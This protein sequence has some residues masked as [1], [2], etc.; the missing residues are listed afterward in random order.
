M[1]KNSITLNLTFTTILCF[2]AYKKKLCS[3]QAKPTKVNKV[4]AEFHS[5]ACV[6]FS[7]RPIARKNTCCVFPL[8]E[9]R[10]GMFAF[11]LSAFS[12][13]AGLDY[14]QTFLETT[15]G[16]RLYLIS[17]H[18]HQKNLIHSDICGFVRLSTVDTI[19]IFSKLS[20]LAHLVNL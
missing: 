19:K 6:S 16:E 18:S 4:L 15:K 1:L 13:S 3:A 12:W 2:N 11:L 9:I 10:I 8:L 5:F 7:P 14:K 20:H 17:F